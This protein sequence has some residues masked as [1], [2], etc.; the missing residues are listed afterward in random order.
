M[1]ETPSQPSHTYRKRSSERSGSAGKIVSRRSRA[2]PRRTR[3]LSSRPVSLAQRRMSATNPAEYAKSA[4]VRDSRVGPRR[5]RARTDSQSTVPQR[6]AEFVPRGHRRDGVRLPL[7]PMRAAV[8][9]RSAD[10]A[11]AGPM[12][13]R[14]LSALRGSAERLTEPPLTRPASGGPG[15]GH[16][17]SATRATGAR[18]DSAVDRRRAPR[19]EIE[20]RAARESMRSE[21][22]VGGVVE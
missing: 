4:S 14:P 16:I 22:A 15:S 21:C 18:P 11:G 20:H 12:G 3:G 10:H 13:R 2:P 6:R 8:S 9:A 7:P 1:P 19:A 17:G 5:V